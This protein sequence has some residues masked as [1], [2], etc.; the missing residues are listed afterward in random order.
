MCSQN[1][2]TKHLSQLG[3][4]LFTLGIAETQINPIQL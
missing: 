3:Q 2:F 4:E 1:L